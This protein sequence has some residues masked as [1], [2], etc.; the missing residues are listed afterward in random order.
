MDF[1]AVMGIA[2]A[3]A[4]DAF[5]VALATGMVLRRVSGR[6]AFRL[7]FHFGLFQFL[8][9]VIGWLAGRT[10]ATRIATFDHWIVFALLMA[11]GGKMIK[12][13]LQRPSDEVTSADPTKG[14][15]LIILSVATSLDALAV[16]MSMALL[17]VGIVFPS[18]VIGIVAA[19]LTLVGLRLGRV[20]GQR[21]GHRMAIVGGVVLVAIG[22]RI[23]VEHFGHA[24]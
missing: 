19:A 22:V 11:V 5:A 3:L 14:R 24:G 23:L 16:G 15:S 12:D 1:L 17:G 21:F 9:P 10:I 20:L 18:I 7:S 8:M 6:Q 2:L 13:G 4:M